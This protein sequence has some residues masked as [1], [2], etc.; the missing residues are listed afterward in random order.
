MT[1]VDDCRRSSSPV[2]SHLATSRGGAGNGGTS[3]IEVRKD[4][5][6]FDILEVLNDV[7]H[8]V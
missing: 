3:A 2:A 1:L 6:L 7:F 4:F 5:E 8:F